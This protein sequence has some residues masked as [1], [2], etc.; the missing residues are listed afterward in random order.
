MRDSESVDVVKFQEDLQ[1]MATDG[2]NLQYIVIS[3]CTALVLIST[4]IILPFFTCVLRDK[5][6]VISIFSDI[7][8]EE[9]N[10][11]IESIKNF[12]IKTIKFKKKWIDKCEGKQEE[13]W[14]IIIRKHKKIKSLKGKDVSQSVEEKKIEIHDL[15][16]N[17][18]NLN[19]QEK[20]L[21]I[22]EEASMQN[23]SEEEKR[24]ERKKTLGE[25]E[26]IVNFNLLVMSLDLGQ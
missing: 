12:D 24:N 15:V 20:S 4:L 19:K 9:V 5:S 22:I 21:H 17:P 13:F 2:E 1:Q 3:I 8:M 14:N 7:E 16:E 23:N 25:I 6:S 10:E 26:Y 18:S 11:T